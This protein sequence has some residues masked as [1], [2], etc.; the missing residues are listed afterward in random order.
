MKS[1]VV[2]KYNNIVA[3]HPGYYIKNIIKD[4]NLTQ[5]KFAIRLGITPKKI[6]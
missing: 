6:R 5:E 3:F 2:I 4:M 1:E